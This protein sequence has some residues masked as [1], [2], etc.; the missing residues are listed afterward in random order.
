[1]LVVEDTEGI[2][3]GTWV[4]EVVAAYKQMRSSCEVLYNAPVDLAVV[5]AS[6]GESLHFNTETFSH[7]FDADTSDSVGEVKRAMVEALN[8]IGSEG[9]PVLN[10]EMIHCRRGAYVGATQAINQCEMVKDESQPLSSLGV[11]NGSTVFL[12]H[13]R[14][15][16]VGHFKVDLMVIPDA[17]KCTGARVEA[18]PLCTLV[19]DAS[20][21]VLQLKQALTERLSREPAAVVLRSMTKKV[22]R[23]CVDQFTLGAMLYDDKTLRAACKPRLAD[24]YIIGVQKLSG[25]APKLSR[26]SIVVVTRRWFP[27]WPGNKGRLAPA[28]EHVLRKKATISAVKESLSREYTGLPPLSSPSDA[29]LVAKWSRFSFKGM[30]PLS[31]TNA[32]T[33]DWEVAN[34][35]VDMQLCG[36]ELKFRDDNVLVHCSTSGLA[37]SKAEIK[38]A[39]A[40]AAE[41][42]AA[43]IAAAKATV[44]R[45]RGKVAKACAEPAG[46]GEPAA[47]G[48]DPVEECDTV[49]ANFPRFLDDPRP[50]WAALAMAYRELHTAEMT[51]AETAAKKGKK[52]QRKGDDALVARPRPRN[53]VSVKITRGTTSNAVNPCKGGCGWDLGLGNASD[54]CSQ[55]SK[56]SNTST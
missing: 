39:K 7:K 50:V 41:V 27:G 10:P 25:P 37:Q 49:A 15:Y 1:V 38:A 13:G 30:K 14:P 24:G 44:T 43:A 17:G 56:S 54:F 46:D 42:T 47:G 31:F 26:H 32:R 4:S 34:A 19:L 55:C 35:D 45:C 48:S 11:F 28:R 51:A 36:R 22:T 33:L 9:A 23:E 8:A 40:K 12:C 3:D 21:T 18:T 5:E 53:E 6:G 29:I 16:A 2:A 52:G 20:W